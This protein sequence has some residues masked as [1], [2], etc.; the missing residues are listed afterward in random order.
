MQ[1]GEE[2]VPIQVDGEAWIQ[3]PGIIRIIHKNRMKMLCRNRALESSLK[4]WQEKQRQQQLLPRRSCTP[5]NLEFSA[6]ETQLLLGFIEATATLIKCVKLLTLRHPTIKADL[7]ELAVRCSDNLEKVHPGGKI[8]QGIELRPL[9]TELVS[10]TRELHEEACLMLREKG[11]TLRIREDFENQLS[12]AL[13]NMESEFRKCSVAVATETGQTLVYLIQ[14]PETD[15]KKGGR[16]GRG[17]FWKFRREKGGGSSGR[18]G[19]EVA[20]W[21]VAEVGVWLESLQLSEYAEAFSRHDVRGRELLTLTRRDLKD[22]GI[23]KV[24]HVK[25]ILQA[26]RELAM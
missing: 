11:P 18:A 7:Y 22:L 21:G 3:P 4:T 14:P 15:E 5:Q 25:R 12:N 1:L 8:L 17:L 6:E 23:T 13:S 16:G 2:G 9:L 26:V 24:G 19:R 20:S 10:T